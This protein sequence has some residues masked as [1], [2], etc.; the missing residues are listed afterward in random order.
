MHNDDND[1]LAANDGMTRRRC[2]KLGLVAAAG[3]LFPVN[4]LA[5]MAELTSAERAVSLYNTHTGE[6]LKK[7]VFW[8]DGQYVPE[9]L[10]DLNRLL[11]DHRTGDVFPIEARLFDLLYDLQNQL[12]AGKQF[13]IISGYRSPHTNNALRGNRAKTGVAKRS[14]HM[15]GK[16]IDI[17][18]PG[19][20]LK[21]LRKSALAMKRGGVG[22]YPGS[23]F[24]HVDTGRVRWWNG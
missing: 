19:C 11:R 21:L 10:T 8:A 4:A 7:A 22:Y 16:A 14:L 23:N 3:A 20:D 1:I 9:T 5:R 24:I 13:H 18:L 15:K 6:S 17:R 12:P 2:L